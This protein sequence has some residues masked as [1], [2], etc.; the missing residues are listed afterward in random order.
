MK[1]QDGTGA[2]IPGA[3]VTLSLGTAPCTGAG[4][5][6]GL[7]GTTNADGFLTFPNV[8]ID[9]GGVG[10][11]LHASATPPGQPAIVADSHRFGVQGF[12][13]TNAMNVARKWHTA[14][15]LTD[16]RVLIAGG[17]D[18]SGPLASAEIY[19]PAHAHLHADG[20]HGSA[21]R[22]PLG[23]APANRQGAHRRGRLRLRDGNPRLRG[24]LRPGG[25]DVLDRRAAWRDTRARC[26]GPCF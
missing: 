20:K 4:I 26:T 24:A 9:R 21:A 22:S 14:T 5:G 17:H 6:G 16:G 15:R 23:D 12:C 1:L 25:R 3:L 8:L 13:G 19:D 11:S 18:G 2:A 7:T 10:A